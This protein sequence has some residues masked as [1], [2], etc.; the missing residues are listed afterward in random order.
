M[1]R[2]GSVNGIIDDLGGPVLIL[3]P[4]AITLLFPI[5]GVMVKKNVNVFLQVQ[6]TSNGK[7]VQGVLVRLVVDGTT[8]CTV[9]S[10]STGS[11]GCRFKTALS[12]HTYSWY[13]AANKSGYEQVQS[14]TQ[15]FNTY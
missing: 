11:T 13:G 12:G 3:K 1:D 14:I 9:T 7:P 6:V 15:S 8:V 4:L 2:D 10:A 5:N